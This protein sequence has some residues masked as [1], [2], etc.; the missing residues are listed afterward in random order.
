MQRKLF[1]SISAMACYQNRGLHRRDQD[2]DQD[3]EVQDRDQ[4]Q[5]FKIWV[6]I[7]LETN[8]QVSRTTSLIVIQSYRLCLSLYCIPVSRLLLLLIY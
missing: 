3:S 8:T 6:S 5:D 2:Q 4:D 1:C 7:R